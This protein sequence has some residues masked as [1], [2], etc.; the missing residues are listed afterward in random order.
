MDRCRRGGPTVTAT[1]SLFLD[2]VEIDAAGCWLWTGSLDRHGY[3]SFGV[4][5]HTTR[6][7]RYAYELLVGPI[8]EGLVID[9]LCRVRRCVNPAHLE[10]VTIA[11]NLARSGALEASRQ[12]AL[13]RTHC[14]HGHEF[15]PENTFTN[16]RGARVCLTCRREQEAARRG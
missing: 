6:A 5:R 8:P 13:A 9:H 1:A 16:V 10:P 12:W 2:K 3:G 15:T 4:R 11:V 14:R 7:H